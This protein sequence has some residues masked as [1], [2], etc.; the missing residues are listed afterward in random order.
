MAYSTTLLN[1]SLHTV[2]FS[3]EKM[4]RKIKIALSKNTLEYEKN[5]NRKSQ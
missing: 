4:E 5:N 1:E 3:N 2:R